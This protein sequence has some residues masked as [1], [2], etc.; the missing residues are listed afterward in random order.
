MGPLER[1]LDYTFKDKALL[2]L[3][4]THRSQGG[5]NNERLEFLGDATLGYVVS[6]WL[7]HQY[8]DAREHDLTLMR[9]GLVKGASLTEV[10]REI[11]L[12]EHLL[13]GVG[14]RRS[15]GHQ[16]AS[17]LAN[18]VEAVIGAVLQD[19]GI[20]A[21]ERVIRRLFRG[22]FQSGRI[23]VEKDAKTRLQEALQAR[24][25][26]LPEYRVVRQEGDAHDPRFTV[27]CLLR[28]LSIR[29]EGQASNRRDAEKQAAHLALDALEREDGAGAR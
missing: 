22:R 16:R 6:E 11:G 5:I 13:L 17:I 24:R 3:A 21:A 10:A 2:D 15:G 19:G 12:G 23:G 25:M 20:Q 27:E 7:F 8:P 26:D 9:A 4:L 28:E 29:V 18:A 1:K 14:E